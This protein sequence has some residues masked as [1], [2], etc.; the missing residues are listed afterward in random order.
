MLDDDAD[1]ASFSI[2]ISAAVE[3]STGFLDQSEYV[4]A[5]GVMRVVTC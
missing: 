5:P 1:V 2:S 3:V 4:I